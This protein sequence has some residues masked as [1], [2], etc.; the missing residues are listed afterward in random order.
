MFNSSYASSVTNA[1]F[2]GDSSGSGG[3]LG[4]VIG[5]GYCQ[6]GDSCHFLREGGGKGAVGEKLVLRGQKL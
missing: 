5:G 2:Y 1:K 3:L 6:L 4:E